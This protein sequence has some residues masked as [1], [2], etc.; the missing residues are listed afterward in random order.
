M[1]VSHLIKLSNAKDVGKL[2]TAIFAIIHPPNNSYWEIRDYGH[3]GE[4][5]LGVSE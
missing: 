1:F 2:L 5:A 3:N 4:I